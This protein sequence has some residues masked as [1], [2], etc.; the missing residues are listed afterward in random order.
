MNPYSSDEIAEVDCLA[1]LDRMFSRTESNMDFI[2]DGSFSDENL[3]RQ[4]AYYDSLVAINERARELRD[5]QSLGDI[6]DEL[7]RD[8]ERPRSLTFQPEVRR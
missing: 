5:R 1:E 4:S 7:E 2:D 3:S 6:H 8:G